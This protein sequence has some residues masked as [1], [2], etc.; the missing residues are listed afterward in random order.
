MPRV[1]PHPPPCLY[2]HSKFESGVI[3]ITRDIMYL[4]SYAHNYNTGEHSTPCSSANLRAPVRP[5]LLYTY[6]TS[7]RISS[8][9]DVSRARDHSRFRNVFTFFFFEGGVLKSRLIF[10]TSVR[11]RNRLAENTNNSRDRG[12]HFGAHRYRK[13]MT[14]RCPKKSETRSDTDTIFHHIRARLCTRG[15]PAIVIFFLTDT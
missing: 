7:A 1:S 6:K 12:E 3:V 13:R 14:E 2:L 5:P 10:P 8:Y 9:V 15:W 4:R 11:D